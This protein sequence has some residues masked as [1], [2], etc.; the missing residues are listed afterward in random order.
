MK[1]LFLMW[2]TKALQEYSEYKPVELRECVLV[3]HDLH[4]SEKGASFKAIR[5][6][7]KQHEVNI[8]FYTIPKALSWQV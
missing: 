3:L 7:Y 1:V 6:K 4:T 2:Q 8:F 5:T